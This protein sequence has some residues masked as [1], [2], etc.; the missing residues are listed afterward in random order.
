[1]SVRRWRSLVHRIYGDVESKSCTSYRCMRSRKKRKNVHHCPIL[2]A[3][4]LFAQHTQCDASMLQAGSG[5][6]VLYEE[7]SN[8]YIVL[9]RQADAKY[10]CYFVQSRTYMASCSNEASSVMRLLL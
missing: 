6:H 5:G 3:K 2:D 10:L 8:W 9:R 7:P 4:T 1:M